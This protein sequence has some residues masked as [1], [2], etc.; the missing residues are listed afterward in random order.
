[1]TSMP[2]SDRQLDAFQVPRAVDLFFTFRR[3]T[4][5]LWHALGNLESS[6][7]RDRLDA[8]RI[9][10][11]IYIAG[12]PRSG[13]TILLE[14]IA[15]HPAVATHQY[16]DLWSIYTP[17]WGG[18][19]KAHGTDVATERSHGDGMLVTS[20]SPEAIEEVL[21]MSFFEHLHDPTQNNVLNEST[22]NPKFEAFYRDHVKKLMLTRSKQRF[23][24]KGNYNLARLGYIQKLFEDAR[25]V[26]PIRHPRTH[27]A[28][29]QKQH[30][31]FQA[32]A[33]RHPRSANYLD[34]VGHF[35]FGA[36]R[37]PIHL[38]DDECVR[39]IIELWKR[40]DEVRGWARLWA[41]AYGTTLQQL[42]EKPARKEACQVVRFEDLCDQPTAALD[43]LFR[44]ADLPDTDN[45][46]QTWAPRLHRPTYYEPQFT[47]SE[48]QAIEEE[49]AE[50][51]R[52]FGYED[53][54][55]RADPSVSRLEETHL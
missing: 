52:G 5:F 16:R 26:I 20:E 24:A 42:E 38:G 30:R 35:E 15:T 51:A 31:L 32:A 44:H 46:R 14:I 55:D 27:I 49:T 9:N 25:F 53:E 39:S 34:H 23:A 1:M 10:Q 7:L 54:P 12:L 6:T 19:Q 21:W 47:D 50:V 40:G 33:A 37:R 45:L 8:F 18:R 36:H 48:E 4:A 28:S 17:H 29:L 11:P 2:F 41:H 13:S 22:S 3:R 43:R